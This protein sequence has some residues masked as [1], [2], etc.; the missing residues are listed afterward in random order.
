P[1]DAQKVIRAW[2]QPEQRS[3]LITQAWLAATKTPLPE[4]LLQQILT[5]MAAAPDFHTWLRDYAPVLRYRRQRLGF[6]VSQR[7]IDGPNPEDFYIVSENLPLVTWF[8]DMFPSPIL[9]PALD[10]ALQPL[11]ETLWQELGNPI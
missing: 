8:E 4:P 10:K 9:F 11:R 2:Q 1:A 6:G 3:E 5:S 7:H